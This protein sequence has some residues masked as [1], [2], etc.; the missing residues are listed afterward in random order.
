MRGHKLN[1][2]CCLNEKSAALK[3]KNL[4]LHIKMGKGIL[5]FGDIEI[6]KK[7]FYRHEI[8]IFKKDVDI[9]KIL[10]PKKISS[11]EKNYKY[12]IVYLYNDH[13]VKPLHIML[14]KASA[15]VKSYDGETELM[16][17]L[18]NNNDLV[19]K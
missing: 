18:I 11:G 4:L 19:E 2:K 9:E 14:P 1:A 12:F 16:D 5:M 3:N 13:R 15:Y 17:F 7:K 6:E 8:P 10:A